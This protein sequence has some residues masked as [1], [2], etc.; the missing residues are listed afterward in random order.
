MTLAALLTDGA[1]HA[2]EFGGG[3]SNHLPMALLA[4]QRLGADDA[5]LSAWHD[6]YAARLEPAPP[7]QAWPAGDPWPGRLG[8]LSAWSAY[9]DLF[10]QWIGHEGGA[11]VLTQVLPVLM[12]GCGAAA[13]HGPIRVAYAARSGHAGELADGLAYWACRFLPLG[14]LPTQ[15]GARV[16]PEPLLGK[17]R[18]G[19]SRR[20][21]IFQRMQDAAGD[22]VLHAQVAQLAVD[23]RTLERLARLSARVYAL[24]LSLIH[25]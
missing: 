7:A 25:I 10:G 14:A 23:D 22:P 9:R 12:P 20:G 1:R 16:D 17:L 21:L 3:L 11:D 8:D 24:S 19:R 15:P 5:R 2:P 4:L 13:F 6:R 18:A